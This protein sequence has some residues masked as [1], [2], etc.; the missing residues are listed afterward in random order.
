M[1]KK[2]MSGGSFLLL[3]GVALFP[4]IASENSVVMLSDKESSSSN[5]IKENKRDIYALTGIESDVIWCPTWPRTCSNFPHCGHYPREEF[6]GKEK[7]VSIEGLVGFPFCCWWSGTDEEKPAD[8]SPVTENESIDGPTTGP[9]N[10][11][12]IT[13]EPTSSSY[14]SIVDDFEQYAGGSYNYHTLGGS[15]D[16]YSIEDIEDVLGCYGRRHLESTVL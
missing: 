8:S 10:A 11:G 14:Y 13:S 12:V 1:D 2:W 6:R 4:S 7:Q 5:M 16:E 15:D 3:L 9:D